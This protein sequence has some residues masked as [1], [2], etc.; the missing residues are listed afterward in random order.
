MAQA[1]VSHSRKPS[2]IGIVLSVV[3]VMV[4]LGFTSASTALVTTMIDQASTDLWIVS[5]GAKCF[6][7]PLEAANSA[8]CVVSGAQQPANLHSTCGHSDGRPPP[9]RKLAAG[10]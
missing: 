10:F 8:A 5:S 6:D 9:P 7:S 4:Q 1:S 2:L 3:L